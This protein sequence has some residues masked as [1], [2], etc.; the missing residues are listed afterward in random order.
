MPE[1]PHAA[2][3]AQPSAQS[4]AAA[5]SAQRA[6]EPR[7][8]G[9]RRRGW[10][11]PRRG[12]AR[13][14]LVTP[15]PPEWSGVADYNLQL[16]A[17]L[18]ERVEVAVI[19]ARP[20]GEYS[21]VSNRGVRLVGANTRGLPST[22]RYDRTVYCMGNSRFHAHVF[23]L[24]R[25][26]P[27]AVVFHDV[28]LMGFFGSIAG[29]ERPDDPAGWLD[30]Q[31]T[32]MYGGQQGGLEGPRDQLYMTREI[33]RDAA[34]CFV[35]SRYALAMLERDRAG[36]VAYAPAGTLMYALPAVAQDPP[37]RA[38]VSAAPLVVTLGAVAAVKEIAAAISGFALL[39]RDHPTARLVIAGAPAAETDETHWHAYAREHAPQARI[40]IAGRVSRARYERLL[41]DADVAMQLRR[42]SN[43]EA[44]GATADCLAAGVPTLVSDLGWFAE[45]PD[46]AVSR[47]RPEAE[48]A[49]IAARLE[50]LLSDEELR[51]T[52]SDAALAYARSHTFA[53]AAG[54]Y[55]AALGLD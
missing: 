48:P 26:E 27:D 40:E 50:E 14:A 53:A 6:P 20:A 55:L 47:V 23:E 52:R 25:R 39:A 37:V 36:D 33:Q 21:R 22:R 51:R 49:Q 34:Q 5:E 10:L 2:T 7:A 18:A 43:G 4:H 46:E 13:I 1:R 38:R 29:L 54:E 16:V 9:A 32:E 30:E 42:R 28:Q 44:S 45:L 24:L 17:A 11:A 35:H 8:G 31:V 12:R 15:W 19:T 41:G 3:A